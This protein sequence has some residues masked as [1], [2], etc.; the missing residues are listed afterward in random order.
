MKYTFIVIWLL[1]QSIAWSI[2][3]SVMHSAYFIWNFKRLNHN[4]TYRTSISDHEINHG[5]GGLS[6][7]P[8]YFHY[9]WN[10][11]K[12]TFNFKFRKYEN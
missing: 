12:D 11:K 4:F 5:F 10:I 9:L 6:T 7:H 3:I 8:S 2:Y 1:I